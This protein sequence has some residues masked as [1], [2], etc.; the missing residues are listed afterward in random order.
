MLGKREG[1]FDKTIDNRTMG[2]SLF[3]TGMLSCLRQIR[4][5]GKNRF[6][7]HRPVTM[8][9]LCPE[10][11]KGLKR[12]FLSVHV[13]TVSDFHYADNQLVVFT[14]EAVSPPL[15]IQKRRGLFVDEDLLQPLRLRRSEEQPRE[16]FRAS[17]KM[18]LK[19]SKPWK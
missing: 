18:P 4:R 10:K 13:A 5:G 15:L 19:S 9:F 14:V 17:E 2:V 12:A 6:V 7:I 3:Y 8:L 11:P 16:S 1:V